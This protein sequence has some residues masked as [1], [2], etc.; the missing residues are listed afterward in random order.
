MADTGRLPAGVQD[1]YGAECAHLQ[2]LRA[3][4]T[5][6]FETGGYSPVR[7]ATLEYYDTY[8]RIGNAVPQERMFKLSD[9]DGKL[10]VLRP[11]VTLAI[12]RLAATKLPAGGARLYYFADKWDL[13]EAGGIWGREVYQAGVERL[14]EEG[15]F[16]DA[17]TIAFAIECLK[18]VGLEHFV[19]DIGHVGFFKG[20]LQ[21]CGLNDAEAEE[22]RAYI[23]G[24]DSFGAERALH[25]AGAAADA[26]NAV[27]TLPTLF[28]GA[29]VL[30]RAE[31]VSHTAAARSALA[32]LK[33]IYALLADMGYAEYLRFD[34][35]AVKSL[36]YYSGVI[37]SGLTEKLGAPVLSGGRYDRLADDFGKDIPAVGFALGLKRILTA[38]ERQ[39]SL[40]APQGVEI[41]IVCERGAEGRAYREYQKLTAAGKRVCLSAQYGEE[42]KKGAEGRVVY[43]AKEEP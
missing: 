23:N 17:Q 26:V 30:E 11:D 31:G 43:F 29:E 42:G 34:L 15:A 2:R 33:E 24:K 32:H 38:L 22:V 39:G 35:G 25:K 1:I 16:S 10:L 14:G 7:T 13:R 20:L 40:P 19:V 37:F 9:T 27:L 36:S 28:G 6:L 5:R 3:T 8:A 12:S 18:A 41:T 4:L 21:E